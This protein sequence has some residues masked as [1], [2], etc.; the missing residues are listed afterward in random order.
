MQSACRRR[1]RD[2]GNGL[3]GY[4]LRVRCPAGLRCAVYGQM[5]GEDDKKHL[6]YRFMNLLGAE[7]WGNDGVTRV[8]FELAEI[9]CRI[10][11]KG[12]FRTR[13]RVPQSCIPRRVYVG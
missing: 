6:P 3:A 2:S 1:C 8:Y 5:E 11:I 9:S 7:A 10:S 13:L 4:D 12:Q